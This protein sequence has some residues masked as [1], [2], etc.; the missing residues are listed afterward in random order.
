MKVTDI[1]TKRTRLKP[2]TEE[3]FLDMKE[4]LTDEQTMAFF[5]HGVMD[6]ESI[7]DLMKKTGS[8]YSIVLKE[9]N[10]TIGHFIYHNWFMVHTFEIGWVLNRTYHNQGIM[11][12][13]AKAV[14]DFAFQHDNAHRVIATCQPENIASKRIC[15][16]LGMR[17][18]GLFQKCIFVERVDEWWDELFYAMLDSEY[19]E[20]RRKNHV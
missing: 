6:D 3:D 16:K 5:D 1:E 7:K 9:T 4:Y 18:E 11:T 15:E 14:L 8:I 17:L 20:N 13:V 10:K 2:V 12:E 19:K